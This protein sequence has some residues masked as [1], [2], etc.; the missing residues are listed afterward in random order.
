M[1]CIF[2]P[3]VYTRQRG[4]GDDF[5]HPSLRTSPHFL[6][7][8]LAHYLHSKKKS[9]E[10]DDLI[11]PDTESYH[12]Y[13]QIFAGVGSWNS[14][15]IWFVPCLLTFLNFLF[16]LNYYESSPCR[17]DHWS[18]SLFDWDLAHFFTKWTDLDLAH[19]FYNL[20]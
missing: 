20:I 11:W 12:N 19:F 10:L 18:R 13:Y 2:Q 8:L 1:F 9:K 6:A 4:N 5:W 16:L 3:T 17:S 7:S 15:S 14:I